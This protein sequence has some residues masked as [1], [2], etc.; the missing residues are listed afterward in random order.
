MGKIYVPV[1]DSPEIKSALKHAVELASRLNYTVCA[2]YAVNRELAA[3]LERYKIFLSEES[4]DF[5]SSMRQNCEK[6][7]N[8]AKSFGE[9]HG[10]KIETISLEGEPFEEMET[11]IKKDASDIKILCIA[12]KSGGEL[13]KDIFGPLER[14]FLLYS[15]VDILVAGDDA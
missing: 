3:K 7:L 14:K 11:F 15:P 9:E 4:A 10:V 2:M 13:M 8:Y 12:K 6:Y 1:T 5:T